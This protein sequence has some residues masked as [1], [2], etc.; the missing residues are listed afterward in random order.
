MT[1]RAPTISLEIGKSH[2]RSGPFFLALDQR[3]CNIRFS[4]LEGISTITFG[5]VKLARLVPITP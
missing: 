5:S 4:L 2:T 3:K 1:V